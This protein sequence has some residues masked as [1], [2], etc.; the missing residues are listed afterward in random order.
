MIQ[1][2]ILSSDKM[3]GILCPQSLLLKYIPYFINT[4]FC[5]N[6]NYF[7]NAKE[8]LHIVKVMEWKIEVH[9]AANN[10]TDWLSMSPMA[11]LAEMV[12]LEKLW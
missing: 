5:C 3:D 4:K 10:G 12:A 6:R 1:W 11:I 7:R 9:L 8:N 2:V